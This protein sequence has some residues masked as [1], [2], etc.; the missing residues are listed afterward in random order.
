[1]K[2]DNGNWKLKKINKTPPPNE[3]T[4][5]A[6]SFPGG[7]WDKFEPSFT[8]HNTSEDYK[9][10]KRQIFDCQFEL[11]AY[12]EVKVSNE[13]PHKQRVEHFHSKRDK[14]NPSKNWALDWQN[15]FGVCLGGQDSDKKL[16]PLP[17]NL[18]CDA[19]KEIY[20]KDSEVEGQVLNPLLLDAFPNIFQ[21]E[22]STGKLLPSKDVCDTI[23]IADNNFDSTLE[24]VENTI[25]AF[26]LN[27]HRLTE[28]RRKLL[29]FY[30]SRLK[31]AREIGDRD[32]QVKLTRMWFNMTLPELFTTRRCLLGKAAEDRLQEIDYDG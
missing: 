20:L 5:F 15:I 6:D 16:H 10:L 19:Y 29:Y 13:K 17:G 31:K 18:S 12:C 21:F 22:K 8:A 26:N 9:S 11:C 28:K 23:T 24:L 14:S 27:C 32:W 25:C 7:Y 3:L 2:T 1:M 30:E 4:N